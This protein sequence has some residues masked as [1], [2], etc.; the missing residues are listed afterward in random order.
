MKKIDITELMDSYTDNEFNIGGEAGAEADKVVSAVLPQVKQRKRVKPL[1]KVIAAA[2]AVLAGSAAAVTAIVNSHFTSLTNLEISYGGEFDGLSIDVT[3]AVVPINVE[4][5]NRL[6]FT[7]NGEHIDITD[8]VDE[9]TPYIYAY[10]NADGD[11]CYIIVGGAAG[12]YG[13]A[14][15]FHYGTEGQWYS[16]GQNA[17]MPIDRQA[18][19]ES[20]EAFVRSWYKPWYAA[21]LDR[22]SL[23]DTHEGYG[24]D[25]VDPV[26]F[27]KSIG[28]IYP[29]V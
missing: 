10:V 2:A 26:E 14:D 27:N 4:T 1:F 29:N 16:A 25:H 5:G 22:L 11:D 8:L 12:D 13:Y 23:W 9:N 15:L 21:A 6:I 3:D 7:A 24:E 28:Y 19:F 20:H 17:A 18:E